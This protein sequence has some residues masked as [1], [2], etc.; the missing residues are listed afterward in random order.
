MIDFPSNRQVM[1]VA[2]RVFRGIGVAAGLACGWIGAASTHAIEPVIERSTIQSGFRFKSA[3]Q[4][5][6]GDLG[7]SAQWDLV[8][9][10]ID[11]NS[12]GLDALH[13]DRLPSDEDQPQANFFFRAASEGGRLRVDLRSVQSIAS[14]SS[15]SWHPTVRGPQ[16]FEVY[17]CDDS[18]TELLPKRPLDP[19]TCGWRLVG[20]VDTRG[21]GPRGADRS[22]PLSV[23]ISIA[24][25]APNSARYLLLDIQ[26]PD[27]ADPFAQTFFSELD[28]V[29]RGD[30]ATKEIEQPVGKMLSVA[31]DDDQ[32]QFH[33]DMS[34]APDLEAWTEK[35]LV[36]V[37]KAWYPKI[38]DAL[39]SEGYKAPEQVR[40]RFR[41]QMQ[42]VPAYAM[43]NTIHLNSSWFR[44][45]LDREAK[46]AVVHELVH[47]VQQYQRRI[48]SIPNPRP[49]PGWV[50][51]GVADYVRWFQ[52]EPQSKGAEISPARAEGAKHDASYRVTANF[53]DWVI[54]NHDQD[55]LKHLNAAA[56]QTRYD[57]K[58]WVDRTT[59]SLPEL[60]KL[61]KQ[62]LFNQ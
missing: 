12:G 49:A 43:G 16:V 6:A 48:R 10:T 25:E 28:V 53:L 46:G 61:W 37:V 42:G 57:E 27:P 50:V 29:S 45:E 39:P 13:D 15:Y 59:H 9:G 30:V 62:S 51:E 24:D 3:K 58:L 7:S 60:E 19:A 34:A 4:P 54:R 41:D 17:A 35:E 26:S 55:L 5:L 56:R 21:Q 18:A 8:D 32:Y 20:R 52:Y 38:V 14:L 44:K 47:V 22:A 11:P 1:V 36:P 23:T 31:S 2:A 33:F 40:L